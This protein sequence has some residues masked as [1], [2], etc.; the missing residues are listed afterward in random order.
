MKVGQQLVGGVERLGVGVAD[1]WYEVPVVSG[2]AELEGRARGDDVQ[3]PLRIEPVGQPEQ[4]G[5][6]GASS[7]MEHEQASRLAD[8]RSL[9]VVQPSHGLKLVPAARCAG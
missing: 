5:F 1:A 3:A 4:V 8:G 6:V 7:V 2:A 9:T